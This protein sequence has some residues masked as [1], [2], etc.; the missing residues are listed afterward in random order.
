MKV[1]TMTLKHHG[2]DLV[3]ATDGE[4]G[5]NLAVKEKP[6]LIIVD[7]RLP[8]M[9]GVEVTKRLREMP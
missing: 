4:V 8:K 6:D 9:D 5:L 3:Q 1:V 7:I 2:Y